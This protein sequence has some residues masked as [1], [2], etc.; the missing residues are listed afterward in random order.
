MPAILAEGLRAKE[1]RAPEKQLRS[2]M[3][4]LAA[5]KITAAITAVVAYSSIWA[6]KDPIERSCP[7]DGGFVPVQVEAVPNLKQSCYEVAYEEQSGHLCVW[8]GGAPG[9]EYGHTKNFDPKKVTERGWTGGGNVGC[10][11]DD[12]FKELCLQL[13]RN[14][15]RERARTRFNP[16]VASEKLDEFFD[17]SAPKRFVR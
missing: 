8:A 10:S 17:P 2:D 15:D 4:R 11:A 12:C 5:L 7:V 6:E 1:A 9:R 14:H 13:V 3:S 16:K